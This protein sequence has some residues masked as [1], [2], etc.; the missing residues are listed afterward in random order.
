M[1]DRSRTLYANVVGCV[2][3]GLLSRGKGWLVANHYALHIG[4]GVGVGG[5][6]PSFS[7]WQLEAS[8]ALFGIGSAGTG[9]QRVMEFVGI[10]VVGLSASLGALSFGALA[11]EACWPPPS[12]GA[13][14]ATAAP[15]R[16]ASRQ[17]LGLAALC[18]LALA[19]A[20]LAFA[21]GA[22]DA[23]RTFVVLLAPVGVLGR[24]QLSRA[25]N[26]KRALPYGTHAANMLGTA[27]A[28]AA[29]VFREEAT[30]GGGAVDGVLLGFCGCLTTVSTLATELRGLAVDARASLKYGAASIAG[31]QVILAVVNGVYVAEWHGGGGGGSGGS[32]NATV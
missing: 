3:M 32:A 23:V 22:D 19:L 13:R 10:Q 15:E 31:A 27:V 28:G 12:S 11:A 30:G 17:D 9:G 8:H 25:L 20:A 2:L 21:A 18:L 6:V 14:A 7:S 24:F 4:L 1:F 29:Y 16:R 26:N 5:S